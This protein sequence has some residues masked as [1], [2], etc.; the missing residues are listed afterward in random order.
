MPRQR[1]P[2]SVEEEERLTIAM[3]GY[4][5]GEWKSAYQAAKEMKVSK[6]TLGQR[7]LG[8]KSRTE[9]R[10][11]QQKLTKAEEKVLAEW[12]TRLTATGHPARHEFIHEMAEEIRRKRTEEIDS[13]QLTSLGS[14]WVQ[15]FLKRQPH[16]Q[17]VISHSIEASC[18]KEVTKEV[19]VSFFNALEACM[20][21]YQISWENVYNIDETG[22]F[23]TILTKCRLCC[24][25]G[26]NFICCG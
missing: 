14:S 8:K 16:L 2:E 12:I 11:A 7:L 13:F 18:V 23:Y 9:A 25:H 19:V 24:R 20:A 5:S 4:R 26:T 6:D 15:Q 10:E 1:K 3:A 22:I 21:E 17:T